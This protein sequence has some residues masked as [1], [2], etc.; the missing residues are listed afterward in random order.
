VLIRRSNDVIPEILGAT[1][2][3]DGNKDITKPHICPACG[4]PLNDDGVNLYCRN[5]SGCEPQIVGRIEHFATK[6]AMD[7][8]GL[9]EKT[10]QQLYRDLGIKY[11]YQLYSIKAE[12][13]NTL[14][15][16]KQKKSEN[17]IN[18]LEKSKKVTLDR[19]LYAPLMSSLP[20]CVI[21]A[22]LWRKA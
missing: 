10:A 13:L 9:S 21:S 19:F 7:I 20:Q 15:G 8:E 17:L 11:V 3:F 16:F 14:E 12:Q 2:V 18:A 4:M 6:D 22:I 1:Q 5:I